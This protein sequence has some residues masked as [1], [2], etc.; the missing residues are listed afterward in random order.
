MDCCLNSISSAQLLKLYLSCTV[1][2]VEG[3]FEY[4]NLCTSE[5]LHYSYLARVQGL[6]SCLITLRNCRIPSID[7]I[8]SRKTCI[9]GEDGG[10]AYKYQVDFAF[11]LM[12]CGQILHN[13]PLK[14]EKNLCQSFC[15]KIAQNKYQE[16]AELTL[17]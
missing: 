11:S 4:V 14:T 15:T 13:S 2:H 12:K 16:G 5:C 17:K 3:P 8:T 9:L 6:I 10:V 1:N 7:S